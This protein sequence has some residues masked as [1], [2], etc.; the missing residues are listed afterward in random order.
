MAWSGFIDG[1]SVKP[2]VIEEWLNK[3]YRRKIPPVKFGALQGIKV[4]RAGANYRNRKCE[5]KDFKKVWWSS[6]FFHER[7][8]RAVDFLCFLQQKPAREPELDLFPLN[9]I[10]LNDVILARTICVPV[11]CVVACVCRRELSKYVKTS[12]NGT[13]LLI[14]TFWILTTY[15]RFK[16]VNVENNPNR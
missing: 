13:F 1:A 4:L 7:D 12:P 14:V 5:A 10:T 8:A 6:I 11:A 2:F 3:T 9:K 16:K 15:R